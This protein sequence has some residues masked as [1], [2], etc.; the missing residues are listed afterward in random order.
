MLNIVIDAVCVTVLVVITLFFIRIII[1]IKIVSLYFIFAHTSCRK[2]FAR[3]KNY[4]F[5]NSSVIITLSKY[6]KTLNSPVLLT[7]TLT[8]TQLAVMFFYT[9]FMPKLLL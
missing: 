3:T 9:H 2:T 4:R 8:L 5:S 1:S 6:T 7:L